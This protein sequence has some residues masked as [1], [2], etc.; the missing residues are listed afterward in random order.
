MYTGL[1]EECLPLVIVGVRVE[2]AAVRE[3]FSYY[4]HSRKNNRVRFILVFD[5]RPPNLGLASADFAFEMRAVSMIQ[6]HPRHK[7]LPLRL[8]AW[9]TY[10]GSEEPLRLQPPSDRVAED[11]REI[12]VKHLEEYALAWGAWRRGEL[13]PPDYLE[14]QHSLLTNLALDLAPGVNTKTSYPDLIR[15]LRVPKYWEQD[16][17]D[18][19]S[20]RNRVK[21]RGYRHEAE[22]Y[23]EKYKQM[24]YSVAHRV[25]GIDAMPR[26]AYMLRFDLDPTSVFRAPAM[27]DRNGD[28]KRFT[29]Y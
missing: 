1:A 16:C 12:V 14:A 6:H 29:R 13:S 2:R 25:T 27:F 7:R 18:L 9:V 8:L 22:R 11:K 28:P 15:A 3:G 19:G 26:S 17:L 24:V 23:A 20:D 21:H 10:S 5:G 4:E